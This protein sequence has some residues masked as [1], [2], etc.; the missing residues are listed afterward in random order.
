M[1]KKID[2]DVH[3]FTLMMVQGMADGES[4]F[5]ESREETFFRLRRAERHWGIR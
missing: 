4:L 5:G 1:L 3:R 2:T